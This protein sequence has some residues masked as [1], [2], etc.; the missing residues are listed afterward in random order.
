MP[1]AVGK[2]GIRRH[3]REGDG[4]T[5]EGTFGILGVYFRPDRIRRH[6]VP[7]FARSLRSF[8]IW[9]DDPADPRYNRFV[10]RA[11]DYARSHE[12]LWRPDHIYD[13]L[14]A[15]DYNCRSKPFLGSA[16]FIHAW[17]GPLFPTEGCVA[18]SRPLL[19]WIVARISRDTRIVIHGPG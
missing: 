5:P 3:K 11:P 6:Q 16:I 18:F 12:R 8:D 9:S 19:L 2:G 1:C 7:G 4:A 14:I 15:T 13:L 17:R 10:G